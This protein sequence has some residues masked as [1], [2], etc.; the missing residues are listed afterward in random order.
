MS[1][2]Q[3]LN[4]VLIATNDF[5]LS[6]KERLNYHDKIIEDLTEASKTAH[7]LTQRLTIS[8][9]NDERVKNREERS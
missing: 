1:I 9:N 4:E 7:I 3:K 2:L 8:N 6:W 5:P